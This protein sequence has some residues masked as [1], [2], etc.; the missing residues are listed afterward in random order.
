[1]V[2]PAVLVSVM[3]VRR[4]SRV[5]GVKVRGTDTVTVEFAAN[6]AGSAVGRD[7]DRNPAARLCTKLRTC[8]V[9][10]FCD[11]ALGAGSETAWSGDY[12]RAGACRGKH[13]HSRPR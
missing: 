11:P 13:V 5:H 1:M 3:F 6:V 4:I 12:Q 8:A 7:D 9:V 2:I 10:A